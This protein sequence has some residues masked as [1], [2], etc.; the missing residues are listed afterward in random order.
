MCGNLNVREATSQQVF[1]VTT[2][3]MDILPVF[4]AIDQSHCRPCC[5]EIQHVF[6]QA[7]AATRRITDWYLIHTVLHHASDAVMYRI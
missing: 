1:K 2:F 6:Q 5:A 7:A 4:F 3:C